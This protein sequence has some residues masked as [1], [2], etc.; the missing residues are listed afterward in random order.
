MMRRHSHRLIAPALLAA[1]VICAGCGLALAQSQSANGQIGYLGEWEMKADLT[2]SANG[3]GPLYAG[4]ITLRHVGLCSVN[5]VEEKS[6]T[7]ELRISTRAPGVEGTLTLADDKC[8]V[9]VSGTRAYSGLLRCHDGNDVPINFS[10]DPM[11]SAEHVA[12]PV[13]K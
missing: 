5:G 7:L 9:T 8:H 1:C 3:A 11:R 10:I 4:P 13:G 12:L 6:G 2:T